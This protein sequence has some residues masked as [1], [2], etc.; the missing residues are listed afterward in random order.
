MPLVPFKQQIRQLRRQQRGLGERAVEVLLPIDGAVLELVQQHL[1]VAREPRFGIAHGRE[2]LRI[3]L[4]PPVA[5]PVDDRIAVAEALRHVDHGFVARRVAVRMELADDVADGARGLLRLRRGRQ[6]EIAHRVDDS[7]LHGLQAVAEM[8]QRTI[9]NHVHRV[10]EV[11]L[12]REHGERNALDA[13]EVQLLILHT[14]ITL[15]FR[16]LVSS[17]YRRRDPRGCPCPGANRAD[18]THASWRATCRA[19]R[20]SR[21]SSCRRR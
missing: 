10:V 18:P 17:R 19:S 14:L 21:P 4:R 5:L 15:R 12:L 20:A 6:A 16:R 13:V 3:V 7:P 9:E 8:R 1:R 2:R 11:R